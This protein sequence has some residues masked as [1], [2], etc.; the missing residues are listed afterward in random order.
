M[1]P[2]CKDN[3]LL[4]LLVALCHPVPKEAE[5]FGHLMCGLKKVTDEHNSKLP[6]FGCVGGGWATGPLMAFGLLYH[7][8]QNVTQVI[9]NMC[10]DRRID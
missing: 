7:S 2:P 10:L 4:V 6:P 8:V 1:G 5:S 3:G 9:Q